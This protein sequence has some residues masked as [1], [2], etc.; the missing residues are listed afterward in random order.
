[1][2]KKDKPKEIPY[3]I[4]IPIGELKIVKKETITIPIDELRIVSKSRRDKG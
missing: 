4:E 3:S 1:M 2:T